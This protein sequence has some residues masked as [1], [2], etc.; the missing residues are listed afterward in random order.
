MKTALITGATSGIGEEFARAFAQ[1]GYRLI[2]TGR[3]TDR[4]E[5]LADSLDVPCR[6]IAADLAEESECRRLLSEVEDEKISV[7]INNAGFGA[8]GGFLAT[9]LD[10]ELSMIHV[11]DI[12]MHILFKGVLKKMTQRDQGY[13]LN[14]AS[15]AGLLPGGP[16]MAT[17]Y[18]TKAYVVSLT[19][20]V[21]TEL[22][23]MGSRVHVS[24]LCPGPV[25]TEFNER[26][27]VVFALKGI[28]AEECVREALAGMRRRSVII[29]PTFTMKAA[30]L[31][32]RFAPT[33]MLLR[34]VGSQ[35]KKKIQ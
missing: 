2:I 23:E 34:M 4:L 15:S 5:A 27:D 30:T 22:G 16:Y 19:R 6:I 33:K 35:Q 31:M 24:A 14:V 21:A 25:D 29:V 32:Q 3:R 26:A 28:S 7:F 11:N 13:I 17:Y 8:A 9:D 10:K 20:A 18:A 12:A 1:R